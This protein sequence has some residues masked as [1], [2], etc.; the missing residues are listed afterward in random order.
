MLDDSYL[1]GATGQ[2]KTS[3]NA[4]KDQFFASKLEIEKCEKILQVL[5][6]PLEK[7]ESNAVPISDVIP[8][9]TSLRA[10]VAELESSEDITEIDR[11][12]INECIGQRQQFIVRDIHL[13][14]L[15]L[16][17]RHSFRTHLPSVQEN[18]T[19][20]KLKQYF[21]KTREITPEDGLEN[22]YSPASLADQLQQFILYRNNEFKPGNEWYKYLVEDKSI[23]PVE[24][25]LNKKDQW[26]GLSE[27]GIRTF[28]AP[29]STAD[30]ER[31]F[32][33][34]N[35]IHSPI[36][37]AL[38]VEKTE[39]IVFIKYN[40]VRNKVKVRGVELENG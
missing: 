33:I 23:H 13:F 15:A 6:D 32:S 31:S 36:R 8:S 37:N 29:C 2:Q 22:P 26:P 17:P 40:V 18:L 30:A 12:F 34:E 1:E 11:A 7:F 25:W 9:F 39:K 28:S 19:W 24:F 3:R 20:Q 4:L 16:D 14:G 35:Y 21:V 10:R 27:I 38:G 5:T